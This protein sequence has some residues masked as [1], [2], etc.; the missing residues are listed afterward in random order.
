MKKVFLL[1]VCGVVCTSAMAQTT[2]GSKFIGVNVGNIS[3]AHDRNS[4]SIEVMLF[5]SAGIFLADDFL[6]GSSVTLSYSRLHYDNPSQDYTGRTISYGLAP[7]ARYYFAGTTPH[8]F[9]GQAS[10]GIAR[11]NIKI[12]SNGT[13][14]YSTTDKNFAVGLGYNYFLTPGAALEVIAGYG[15]DTNGSNATIGYLDVRAGFS[16]FLPSR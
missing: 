4:N 5:P 14:K 13:R 11:S 12:E 9:F 10:V 15:R 2:K 8:R 16:V 1:G 7:F 6:L 3:Y